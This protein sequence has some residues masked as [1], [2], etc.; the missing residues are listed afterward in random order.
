M[1]NVEWNQHIG[2]SFKGT[3]LED[4]CPCGKAPCGLV[5]AAKIDPECIQHPW[6]A[7][8]TIRQSHQPQDCKG[9][10]DDQ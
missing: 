3:L 9:K 7:G 1:T 8:R 5:D 6:T 2:R 10:N 4:H